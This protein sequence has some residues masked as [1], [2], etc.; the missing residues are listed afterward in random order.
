MNKTFKATTA[1]NL[2][3][4]GTLMDPEIMTQVTGALFRSQ[5]ATLPHYVRKRVSGEVYPGI[6]RQQGGTV[7]GI[8]YFNISLEAL[9]RLDTFEGSLYVRTEAE[10]IS[11]NGEQ[12]RVHTYVIT[13]AAAPLLSDEDWSYENFIA[14]HKHLFQ[15]GF[16]GYD[17]LK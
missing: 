5:K 12:V 2:F 13:G 9:D 8:V 4:Y 11:D 7:A 17:A 16:R 14:K 15:G 6:I 3:T 1:M 10:T